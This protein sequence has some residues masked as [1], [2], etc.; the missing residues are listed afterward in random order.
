MRPP[1]GP[2]W[3]RR[4]GESRVQG[5]RYRED[6]DEKSLTHANPKANISSP[7][8]SIHHRFL[9][10]PH[11]HL[12]PPSLHSLYLTF[13]IGC[14]FPIMTR[15]ASHYSLFP[16]SLSPISFSSPPACLR[17]PPFLRGYALLF[18]VY[19]YRSVAHAAMTSFT[20]WIFMFFFPRPSHAA[21]RSLT[22]TF[23]ALLMLYSCT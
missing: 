11:L 3:G 21:I 18:V 7:L 12:P 13:L 14:S 20:S 2:G 1:G 8:V 9:S 6:S 10:L 23:H 16:H 4:S 17:R 5:A 15:L 19:C 22:P